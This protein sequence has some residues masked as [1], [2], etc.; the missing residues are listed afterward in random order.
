MSGKSDV[1]EAI[2]AFIDPTE[3]VRLD[4]PIA[5]QWVEVKRELSYAEEQALLGAMYSGLRRGDGQGEVA[6]NV[7]AH[8]VAL[9]EAWIVDWSFVGK[10]GKK[11]AVTKDAIANLRPVFA[12]AIAEVLGTHTEALE[13]AKKA[14]NGK[15][16]ETS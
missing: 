13:E 16:P 6:V 2:S 11:V 12:E 14:L 10:G 8:A 15:R 3:I 5:D 9:F 7:K 4:L 1:A